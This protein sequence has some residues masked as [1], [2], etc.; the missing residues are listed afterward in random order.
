M[1]SFVST[2]FLSTNYLAFVAA[3]VLVG[4]FLAAVVFA[5]SVISIPMLVDRKID[6]ITAIA[7]SLK[8]V[9]LNPAAM[10]VW[11]ALARRAGGARLRPRCCSA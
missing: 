11:A 2:V 8:A 5:M 6:V 7:T 4:G 1:Q 10:T 3:Y 9:R